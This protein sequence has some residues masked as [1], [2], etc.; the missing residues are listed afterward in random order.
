M[1]TDGHPRDSQRSRCY[2]WERE[3]VNWHPDVNN[4]PLSV[5]EIQRLVQQVCNS[6]AIK[7][8]RVK[9]LTGRRRRATYHPYLRLIKLPRDSRDLV[10][11]LHELAHATVPLGCAPHGPEF[12]ARFIKLLDIYAGIPGWW[13]E[14]MT[15][16]YRLQVAG[17]S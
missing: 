14:A 17:Y 11:V 7:P 6:Y 8:V 5:A 2:R 1:N 4:E 16:R 12:M 9:I 13:L 10:T 3:N 15:V